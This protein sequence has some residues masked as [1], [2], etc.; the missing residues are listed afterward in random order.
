MARKKKNKPAKI[1]AKKIVDPIAEMVT[2]HQAP[3]KPTQSEEAKL[4]LEAD[5]VELGA[6]MNATEADVEYFDPKP[7]E[8]PEDGE[9]FDWQ[10]TGFWG[11]YHQQADE[12]IAQQKKYVENE[13]RHREKEMHL[14]FKPLPRTDVETHLGKTVV[15]PK[16]YDTSVLVKELRQ[17]NR[18]HLDIQ[19]GELPFKGY[20]LWNAYEVSCLTIN[21]MPVTGVAKILYPC[22][23]SH[24]VESKSLKLYLNS[25]NMSKFGA[26]RATALKIVESTIQMDLSQLLNTQ[27][28]VFLQSA[29]DSYKIHSEINNPHDIFKTPKNTPSNVKYETL[30]LLQN[31][32]EKQF[33]HYTE[34]PSLL[35]IKSDI[36]GAAE[37]FH[38]HSSLLKSNCKVTN[39]PDWGDVFIFMAGNKVCEPMSLLEYIISFRD[40]NHFHE[41]V[42][43]TIYKRLLD[44]YHPAQLGVACFYSRRGGIDINPIRVSDESLLGINFQPDNLTNPNY[45]L[46]LIRQ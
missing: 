13:K 5:K 37:P 43:E 28:K 23:S 45:H 18:D 8:Y 34:T 31:A 41:E 40:E 20:D 7:I 3:V 9:N 33:K 17:N 19:P 1:A 38:Y 12:V 27:V 15:Y 6:A 22:D 10:S 30:E 32:N 26:S 42:C 46:K 36:P 4:M 2:E 39:Q 11:G 35:K 44:T 14:K 24:I 21:G 29:D 25:F 16:K